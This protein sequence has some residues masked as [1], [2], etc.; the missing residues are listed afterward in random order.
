MAEVQALDP[1]EVVADLTAR[2]HGVMTR[3]QLLEAGIPVDAID[4]RVRSRRLRPLHRGVYLHGALMGKLEPP[5]AREM[6]AVL[7]CGPGSA[8]SHESAARL[9]G[10]LPP[11]V[12]G[13]RRRGGSRD[14]PRPPIH[15]VVPGADRGRR[16]G[17]RPHRVAGL[18]REETAVLEGIPVTAAAR[19]LIDLAAATRPRRLEQAVAEAERRGLADREALAVMLDRRGPVPGAPVL[20]TLLTNPR[21][22]A[23]TRSPAEEGLLDLVRRAGLPEPE[24][25]VRVA[26]VEADFLWPEARVVVEVDGFAYHSSRRSFERD[27]RRDLALT[28]VGLTVIRITWRQLNDEP[29]ALLVHLAQTLARA[30]SPG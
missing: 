20:R 11:V 4:R 24:T 25:N 26:G 23:F 1:D 3:S 13:S 9:W 21:A 5:R 28:A 2:Q 19:T 22:P 6:A 7:A 30:G 27:R 10:L 29:E 15:V 16:A 12:D 8:V 17:V 18:P 14:A